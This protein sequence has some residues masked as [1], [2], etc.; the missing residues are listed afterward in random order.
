MP[1]TLAPGQIELL[2]LGTGTSAGVPMIGC[3][4]EVCTS[5]DPHDRRT[6]PSVVVSY[7][8]TRVL[9]DTTPELRLQCVATRVEKIDAVVFTHGHADHVMGL[10]D[11]RRF[12]AIKQGPLDVWADERTHD[13]LRTCFGYAFRAP[14]P[15]SKLFRP[16]LRPRLIEA[17]SR[18]AR[19]AWKPIPL[20]HGEMPVLGFRVGGLAY[21][22]DVS[23]IP[24]ASF[25]LLGGPG[26]AGAGRAS[27]QEAHDAFFRGGGDRGVPPARRAAD[28]LHA[29]RPRPGARADEPRAPPRHPPGVRRVRVMLEGEGADRASRAG[30]KQAHAQALPR[31]R[32]VLR[33]GERPA[34]DAGS[35]T[36]RSSSGQLP[37]RRQTVLELAVGTGRAAIPIAQAG[38][39][40]VGV[41][42]AADM[43]AIARRKR[44]AVGLTER[45][46]VARRGRRA[47]AGPGPAVRLGLRLLQH[48]SRIHRLARAGRVPASRPP[49]P[50]A[51][52]PALAG[53]LQPRPGPAGP[54]RCHRPG[55]VRLSRAASWTG[56]SSMATDV[57]AVA[58]PGPARDVPLH[59][60][61]RPRA[62]SGDSGSSST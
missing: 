3:R 23:R 7:G 17:H 51:A 59:L 42:Y 34:R 13:T 6:R 2:F 44:D 19:C 18:S 29:H 14:D 16:H 52:R 55:P 15:A 8:D 30:K 49:A 28:V 48:V 60:V 40:V 45:R 24:E 37:A 11:V 25:E 50:Q 47:G 53:H 58:R 35:R 32:R 57:R 31:H 54:A 43:L 41:D 9:V 61:R 26:R 10:D 20:L 27:V 46:T 62:G 33:R 36:C 39:R 1:R 21:C 12:N 5:R 4:C 22:T 38:H 56:P